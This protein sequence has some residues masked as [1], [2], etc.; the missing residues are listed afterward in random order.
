MIMNSVSISVTVNIP[1]NQ[2]FH[3]FVNEIN[4][5]WPKEYTWSQ[6]KLHDIYI[7]GKENGLCTEVGPY[8]FRCDWGRVTFYSEGKRVDLKWQVNPKREPVP[9]PEKASDINIEFSARDNFTLVEFKHFNFENHGNDTGLYCEMLKSE[10]GWPYI[11][12]CYKNQCEKN[13]FNQMA[14]SLISNS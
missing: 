10:Q 12:S 2:A 7:E 8:G 5:W 6:D 9:D 3:I 1:A 13:Y 11:L 14:G 4:L